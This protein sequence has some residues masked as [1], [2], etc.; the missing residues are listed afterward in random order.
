MGWDTVL[1]AAAE[2]TNHP[3]RPNLR[4]PPGS[5]GVIPLLL[6]GACTL[7]SHK[8]GLRSPRRRVGMGEL[9]F[10][11]RKAAIAPQLIEL[12]HLGFVQLLQNL[13]QFLR[14]IHHVFLR[15]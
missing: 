15:P 1:H 7:A 8:I 11:H 12:Y 4:S 3:L 6:L 2:G 10:N 13:C 14:R 9:Q 5:S